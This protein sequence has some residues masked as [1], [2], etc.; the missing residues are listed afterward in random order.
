[1]EQST[2]YFMGETRDSKNLA[3]GR[4]DTHTSFPFELT[5]ANFL[6]E[7]TRTSVMGIRLACEWLSSAEFH[8]F[9]R[10]IRHSYFSI[11]VCCQPVI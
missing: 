1:M 11:T 2:I 7:L 10:N 5:H 9:Q 4:Y 3:A 6:Y 8:S